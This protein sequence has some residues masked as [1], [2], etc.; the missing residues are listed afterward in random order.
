MKYR[1]RPGKDLTTEVV[2]IAETQYDRAIEIM[3]DQPKGR[4]PGNPRPHAKRFY[5]RS[6]ARA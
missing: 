3:R 2:R 1:I 4:F 6:L 5:K